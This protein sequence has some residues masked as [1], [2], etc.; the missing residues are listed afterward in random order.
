MIYQHQ[1]FQLDTERKKVFDENNKELALTGN[2]YRLLVFLC[3]KNNATLTDINDYFD[4][5]GAKDY[6]E[7]HVR[8]YRYKINSI[9]GHG[10]AAYKNN[11][12]SIN[13]TI[14]KYESI[15]DSELAVPKTQ[16]SE[17][18]QLGEEIRKKAVE[19]PQQRRKKISNKEKLIILS[20]IVLL[21]IFS[22]VVLR[23][24]NKNTG[25]ATKINLAKGTPSIPSQKPKNE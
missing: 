13:D 17:N 11:I 25:V 5:T 1:Y 10:I 14:L 2:A 24:K 9:I 15:A 7:N 8:Q 20:L 19:T 22:T 6:T 4:P 12:Y 21:I 23:N 18:N 3:D 16:E